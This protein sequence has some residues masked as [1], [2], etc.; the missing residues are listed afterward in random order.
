MVIK[1]KMRIAYVASPR[2]FSRGAYPVEVMKMADGMAKLGHDVELVVPFKRNERLERIYEYYGV[3]QDFRIK[4]LPC[5]PGLSARHI[6]HGLTASVYCYLK[7]KNF[8]ILFSRNI[9][10]TYLSTV[11]FRRPTVFDAHHPPVGR[12]SRYLFDSFRDSEY[13][14]RFSTNSKGLGDIYKQLGLPAEKLRV[15]PNGVDIERFDDRLSVSE[16]RRKLGLPEDKKI[17]SHVGNFYQ[18]RGIDLLIRAAKE[19]DDIMFLIVGGEEEDIAR[20][21]KISEQQGVDNFV[22]QG[23]VPPSLVSLYLFAADVLVMPYTSTMTSKAGR[24]EADFASPLKLF[25]YI[26]AGRPIVATRIPACTGV[27]ED[28][29]NSLLV[30][31]DNV[32]SLAEGI[33]KVLG[34]EDFSKS[35]S[36]NAA[37]DA[38]RYTWAERVRGILDGIEV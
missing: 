35:I 23:F 5:L 19:L 36:E 31:P 26:A 10:H 11:V 16:A 8:D 29:R 32:E 7:R 27:L 4:T 14:L 13:L 21:K 22:F 38:R 24:V 9:L 37:N 28:G 2:F 12:A 6:V 18:G 1:N 30:E 34:D 33:R 20:Y 15:A 25:E 17:V 3:K